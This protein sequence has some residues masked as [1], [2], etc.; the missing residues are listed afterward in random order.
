MISEFIFISD[1]MAWSRPSDIDSET[2]HASGV[3]PRNSHSKLRSVA[4]TSLTSL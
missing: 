2:R 1:S 4:L 3:L